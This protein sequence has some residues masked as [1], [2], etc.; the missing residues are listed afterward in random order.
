MWLC[1]CLLFLLPILEEGNGKPAGWKSG[2]GQTKAT[3]EVAVDGQE[4]RMV[5][6]L[7]KDF[8]VFSKSS[9]ETVLTKGGLEDMNQ[10]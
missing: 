10:C 6:L 1:V 9:R 5:S 7:Q 8:L 2:K 3:V 4:N